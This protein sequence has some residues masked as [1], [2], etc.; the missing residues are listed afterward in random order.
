MAVLP[1]ELDVMDAMK[2]QAL[3]VERGRLIPALREYAEIFTAKMSQSNGLDGW[4]H[5]MCPEPEDL[6][7][8]LED[9]QE[10]WP[11]RQTTPAPRESIGTRILE[12]LSRAELSRTD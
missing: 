6:V 5:D 3:M 1:S 2:F 12:Y 4:S 11:D 10:V 9:F 7:C 8:E